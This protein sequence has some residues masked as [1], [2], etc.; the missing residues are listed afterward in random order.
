MS[1]LN[2]PDSFF[3][4]VLQCND[5][6]IEMGPYLNLKEA[7]EVLVD[8]CPSIAPVIA[9]SQHYSYEAKV[10]ERLLTTNGK[11]IWKTISTPLIENK[12]YRKPSV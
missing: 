4:V 7:V 3:F 12:F 8:I 2:P 11:T 10:H 5:K 9:K 1:K 6:K